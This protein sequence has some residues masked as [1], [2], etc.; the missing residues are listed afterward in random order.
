VISFSAHPNH[1]W[2]RTTRWSFYSGHTVHSYLLQIW[3]GW[4]KHWSGIVHVEQKGHWSRKPH[5][6]KICS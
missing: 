5:N 2:T 1:Y 3:Q 6:W 4:W